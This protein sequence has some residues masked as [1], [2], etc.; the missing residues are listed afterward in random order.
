MFL[1]TLTLSH[2]LYGHH[3]YQPYFYA[4]SLPPPPDLTPVDHGRR[5]EKVEFFTTCSSNCANEFLPANLVV[6]IQGGLLYWTPD[7]FG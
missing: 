7:K 1:L 2:D 3:D 5:G 6:L 4:L